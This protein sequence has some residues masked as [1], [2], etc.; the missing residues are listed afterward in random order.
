MADA[1]YFDG[2]VTYSMKNGHPQLTIGVTSKLEDNDGGR[3]PP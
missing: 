1:G 3:G 2:A